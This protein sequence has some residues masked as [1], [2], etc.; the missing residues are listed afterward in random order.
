[1]TIDERLEALT[2]SVELSSRMQQ[3]NEKRAAEAVQSN[4]KRFAMLMDTVNR[5][6]RILEHHDITLDDHDGRL[7]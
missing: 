3:D 1:M 2:Q 4:E 6:G 7:D 5:I